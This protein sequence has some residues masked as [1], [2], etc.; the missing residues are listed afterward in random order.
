MGEKN[1]IK[2]SAAKASDYRFKRL[3]TQL[4]IQ[5]FQ[6]KKTAPGP[7]DP[8]P[9][10]D[11]VTT[12]GDRIKTKDYIDKQP[13]LLIF[14]SVT[15]PMTVSSFTP[16]K[17]LYS[18]FGD[19]ITFV[20][21][22][23]REAHPGENYQQPE[24]LDEKLERAKAMKDHYD[25]PWTVA[26]DDIDGSLHRALDTKPNAAYL[27][28]TDGKIA[29]RSLWAGDEQGLE[30]TLERVSAGKNPVK[31]QSV[32]MFGPLARGIGYFHEVLKHAGPQ[33]QRDLLKAAP[34][35]FLVGRIALLFRPLSRNS[36]GIAALA[37]LGSLIVMT[38]GVVIWFS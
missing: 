19:K 26:V 3:R 17:R 32:A 16:L 8:L 13:L 30:Q 9:E 31:P 36:R 21:L 23:V 37:T 12:T 4:L 20:M 34:P 14:G 18:K 5:D 33:A 35:M 22:N 15:C 29:F 1:N 24:T 38:I 10:F 2:G 27:M 6:F 25:I 7:G 11:L 28:N